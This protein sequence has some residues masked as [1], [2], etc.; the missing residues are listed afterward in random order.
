MKKDGIKVIDGIRVVYHLHNFTDK[1]VD[2][3][4]RLLAE[5]ITGGKK[6]WKQSST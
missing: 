4:N 5:A 2:T 6:K 1:T 3:F